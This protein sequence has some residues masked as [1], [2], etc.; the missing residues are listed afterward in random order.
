M[1][2]SGSDSISLNFGTPEVSPRTSSE[3]EEVHYP[4]PHPHPHTT[5]T[6]AHAQGWP[7]PP[8]ER[9]ELPL[10]YMGE[11]TARRRVT[12]T[13]GGNGA[14]SK[15]EGP[16]EYDDEGKDVYA[17]IKA[18][19]VPVSSGRPRRPPPP[20]ATTIVRAVPSYTKTLSLTYPTERVYPSKPR[21]YNPYHLYTSVMLDA[22]PQNR[23]SSHSR[24]GR[25]TLWQVWQPLPE[26]RVLLRCA[27]SAGQDACGLRRPAGRLRRL[28]RVQK[29]R[30]VPRYSALCGH[31]GYDGHVR[32]RNG[33]VGLVYCCRAGY[34]LEG[35]PFS[36]LDGLAW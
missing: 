2:R 3:F 26:A 21:A 31:A 7:A 11:E 9:E 18:S 8:R 16:D 32:C 1:K 24:M 28:L 4:H 35:V 33:A 6:D 30:T 17:K 14:Y 20:P 12:R 36:C 19:K 22:V 23:Q 15:A 10:H 25:G 13:P 27:P 5:T 29:R 34:E